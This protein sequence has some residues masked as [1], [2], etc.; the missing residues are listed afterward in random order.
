MTSMRKRLLG[1]L[2][3]TVLLGGLVAALVV[4][5]Q[6]RQQANELFDYQ[7]RQLALVLRDRAYSPSQLAEALQDESRADF[8]IQ[9]WSPDARLMYSSH[10]SVDAPG[11]VNPDRARNEWTPTCGNLDAVE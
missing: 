6:A 8:V 9:V 7:L 4:F 10:P 3:L 1:W 5:Y 11:P 2:L